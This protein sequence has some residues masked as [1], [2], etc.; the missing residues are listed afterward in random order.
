MILIIERYNL[1]SNLYKAHITHD[2]FAHNKAIKRQFQ[3]KGFSLSTKVSSKQNT[4]QGVLG[5]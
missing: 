2:I 4:I 5:F 3:A 1:R